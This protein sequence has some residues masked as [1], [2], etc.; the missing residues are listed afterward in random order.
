MRAPMF[1]MKQWPLAGAASQMGSTIG[2]NSGESPSQTKTHRETAPA[3]GNPGS[4]DSPKARWQREVVCGSSCPAG[5]GGY[6]ALSE[7]PHRV[8]GPIRPPPSSHPQRAGLFLSDRNALLRQTLF[9]R[10][11]ELP[12][13]SDWAGLWNSIWSPI[14]VPIWKVFRVH[15]RSIRLKMA[16][17]QTLPGA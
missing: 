4:Q 6:R 8:R 1:H 2:K 15:R 10:R 5:E 3:Q 11:Q 16:Q 17:T 7:Q 14:A 13:V 9:L 12:Y